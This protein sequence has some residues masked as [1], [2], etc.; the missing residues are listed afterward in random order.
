MLDLALAWQN[1][2]VSEVNKVNY[3]EPAT[4]VRTESTEFRRG[5]HNVHTLDIILCFTTTPCLVLEEALVMGL[6]YHATHFV[7]I[8]TYLFMLYYNHFYT[9][10]SEHPSKRHC[11]LHLNEYCSSF[12]PYCRI[13]HTLSTGVQR[14]NK[15]NV[16]CLTFLLFRRHCL[17]NCPEL[18]I[19][20]TKFDINRYGTHLSF[21]ERLLQ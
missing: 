11:L 15:V 10:Q 5:G 6:V 13:D 19:Y 21:N 8:E 7:K 9:C 17:F 3:Q 4:P 14:E 1:K 2:H 18:Y 20:Y 12:S 16:S